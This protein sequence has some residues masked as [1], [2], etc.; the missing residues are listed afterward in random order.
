[1]PACNLERHYLIV[2]FVRT[3]AILVFSLLFARLGSAVEALVMLAGECLALG[4]AF[5]FFSESFQQSKLFSIF[6]RIILSL[7]FAVTASYYLGQVGKVADIVTVFVGSILF[8]VAVLVLRI[9]TLT[10][11]RRFRRVLVSS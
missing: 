9:V 8:V 5:Y 2:T 1:M 3:M 11:L 7:A 4:I 6:F 10:E